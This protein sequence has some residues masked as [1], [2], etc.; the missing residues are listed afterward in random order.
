MSDPLLP[1]ERVPADAAIS[2]APQPDPPVVA[3]TAFPLPDEPGHRR[4]AKDEGRSLFKRRLRKFRRLRRGYY[5]F[6]IVVFAYVV[7]FLLPI[8]ANN[9]ALVVKY[10]GQYFFPLVTYHSASE[11]G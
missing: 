6:L 10:R 7:S 4:D 3:P 8:L 5:S 11:F 9:V 1:V 2:A